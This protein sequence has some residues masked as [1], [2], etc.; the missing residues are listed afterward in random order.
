M[1]SEEC[2]RV[3]LKQLLFWRGDLSDVFTVQRIKSPEVLS[4][5]ADILRRHGYEE[6]SRL[7]AGRQ[8][9]PSSICLCYVVQRS[10]HM[11]F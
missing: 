7:L 4:K 2:K 8:S 6:K 5:T 9:R 10:L 11:T 1:T 3:Q